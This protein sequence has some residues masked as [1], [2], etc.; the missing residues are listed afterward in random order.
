MDR[1]SAQSRDVDEHRLSE[2]HR[3]QNRRDRSDVGHPRVDAGNELMM[4]PNEEAQNAR[5]KESVEHDL[6]GEQLLASE[7]AHDFSG[8]AECR[9]Q[10]DVLRM[11]E[12]P[13]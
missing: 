12:E 1:A 13:E 7:N 9:K 6:V 4:R 10:N 11:S 8:N 5:S 3:Y 2:R